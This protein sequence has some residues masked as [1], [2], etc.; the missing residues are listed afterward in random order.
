M[1]KPV[2]CLRCQQ[3]GLHN[4][5]G[6]CSSC[7]KKDWRKRNPD[8]AWEHNRKWREKQGDNGRSYYYRTHEAR[9]MASQK[10]RN[11][12]KK[13]RQ[14]K[15]LRSKY[16]LTFERY[17]ALLDKQHNSCKLCGKNPIRTPVVDHNHRT[18]RIRGIVCQKCNIIIGMYESCPEVLTLVPQYLEGDD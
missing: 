3:V 2:I 6:L 17:N 1:K 13:Q 12:N 8:K 11:L 10:W 9:L 18:G 16:G 5:R 7:Y 15:H 14:E 4:G